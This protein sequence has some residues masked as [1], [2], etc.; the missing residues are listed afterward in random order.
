[1]KKLVYLIG[2]GAVTAM[3]ILDILSK[4]R[5]MQRNMI[6]L[7]NS[8]IHLLIIPAQTYHIYFIN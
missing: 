2:A 7:T 6:T 3:A 8:T 4:N 5:Q 1:M